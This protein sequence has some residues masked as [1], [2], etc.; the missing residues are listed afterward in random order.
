VSA[1]DR[2][3]LAYALCAWAVT[4]LRAPDDRPL[5]IALHGLY[6]LVALAA[7]AAPRLRRAGRVGELLG[8]FYPLIATGAL[9][10]AVGL[11][12]TVV[13]HSYDSLVRGW[14]Q[15]L[16]GGQP[17]RDWIEAQPWPWLSWPLHAAYLSYY[18]I[19]SGPALALWISGRRAAARHTLL[20]TMATFY[21]CYSIFLV[22][23]VAGP[24]YFLPAVEHA[25]KQVWPAVAVEAV[26]RNGDAWGTAFPSSHVAVALVVAVCAWR[27]WRRLGAIVAPVAVLL[28]LGTVYGQFHYA[29]DAASGA[30]LAAAVSSAS[31][32]PRATASPLPP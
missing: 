25:A 22:F 32:R 24:R 2:C 9:Y 31:R 23:P 30:L 19:V 17:A 10:T 5:P 15:A 20:M 18:L 1:L 29:V 28:A 27:A 8:E 26:L 21:I 7:L 11:L 14:E 6:P 12:N 16:F 3:T 4:L 13:G